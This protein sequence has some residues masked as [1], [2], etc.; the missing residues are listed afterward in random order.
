MDLQIKPFHDMKNQKP[1]TMTIGNFDGLHRGHQFLI[2]KTKYSDTDS[3]VLTF[4]PH[5]M[6]VLRSMKDHV[7]LMSNEKKDPFN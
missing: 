3:A 1:L 4:Y 2:E 5:P 6:K 7:I